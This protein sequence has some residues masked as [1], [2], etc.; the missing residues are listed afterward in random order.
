MIE[1]DRP[2]DGAAS[3]A[4]APAAATAGALLRSAREAAGLH[5]AAL[6]VSMKVPVAKLDALERDRHDLLPDAVFARAL[7]SAVCR[8][9]KV[10]AAPVLALLPQSATPRLVQDTDGLNTPFRTPRDAVAPAWREQLTR[11]ATLAVGALLLGIA[12]VLLVPL[13]SDWSAP[14]SGSAAGAPPAEEGPPQIAVPTAA[15]S[16]Q[17]ASPAAAQ[18][19]VNAAV[20]VPAA[21][22]APASAT[23]PAVPPA[24]VAPAPAAAKAPAEG[25]LVFRATGASWIEVRDAQGAV[26]V[27]RLL[28]AGE[29]AGAT[30]APPLQVTVGNAGATEVQVRGK[31]FDLRAVTRDNVARFEVK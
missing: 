16:G 3:A 23:S 20:A 9:L 8:T 6:A 25:L 21:P 26:A 28:A 24:A 15:R 27:R 30:G 11:P 18:P 7:A 2:E 1:P 10:D 12:V 19:A 14:G 22:A 31:A 13:P 5:V 29:S 17:P 4:A